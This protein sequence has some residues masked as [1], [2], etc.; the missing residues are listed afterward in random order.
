MQVK[1]KKFVIVLL[2]P[3]LLYG[4]FWILRPKSFGQFNT[5]YIIFLQSMITC[6]VGWGL[7]FTINMDQFDLAVGAEMI[8]D[9]ILAAMLCR[10]LGIPG[11]VLGCFIGA[12][13]CGSIKALLFKML[14]IPAMILTIAL[15][16]IWG[17]VGG[18]I[19]GSSAQVIASDKSILGQ[20]PWNVIIFILAGCLVLYLNNYSVF[21]M[22]VKSVAGSG[23]LSKSNG[24]NV[25]SVQMKALVISS[26]FAGIAAILQLSHGSSVTPTTGLGSISSILQSIMSVFIGLVMIKQVN[27]I[28]GIF[29]GAFMMSIIRNGLTAISMPSSFYNVV[30]G[31]VLITLMIFMNVSNVI[32]KRQTE[33]AGALMRYNK[34]HEN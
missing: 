3:I 16:Y 30:I 23:H 21:G 17:A 1:I 11:I 14:R 27:I 4:L 32:E 19:T 10:L 9:G 34:L 5:F 29:V 28:F 22:N 2:I 31:A 18:L 20:S 24:I 15:T 26:L 12:L 8:L 25:E 13:I 7:N 6:I 33:K